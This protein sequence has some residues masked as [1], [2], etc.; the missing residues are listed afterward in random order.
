MQEPKNQK[1]KKI[2]HD[3]GKWT[4]LSALRSGSP[5]K[6]GRQVY[7]LIERH[8]DLQALFEPTPAIDQGEFDEWHKRTILKFCEKEPALN[9][10]TGTNYI[11]QAASNLTAPDWISL[12]TNSAPF[13]FIET[14]ATVFSQRYYRA[15]LAP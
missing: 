5:V 4:A 11:V 9:S 2:V 8:A 3:F 7:D 1:R 13:A 14:N 15:R 10:P 6:S 12:R